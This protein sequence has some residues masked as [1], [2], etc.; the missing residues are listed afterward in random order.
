MSEYPPIA[1]YGLIGDCHSVALV[2]RNGSV[3]WCCM[4]RIDSSPCFARLLDWE[5]GGCCSI[6]PVPEEARPTFRSYIEG[7]LVLET[8][9]RTARGQARVIDCFD[10]DPADTER[11]DRRERRLIRIIEGQRGAFEFD[12]RI[13]PRF[14]YGEVDPWIRHHGG[15]LYSAMGGDA[16]LVIWCDAELEPSGRHDLAGRARVRP[17]ERVRLAVTSGDPVGIDEPGEVGEMDSAELDDAVERTIAWWREWSERSAMEGPD[18]PGAERSAVVLKALTYEPTGAIAA[19]ATTSLP[20]SVEGERNWDYRQSWI[21]D[22]AMAVRSLAELGFENEAS[23]FRAFIERSAAGNAKDLQVLYGLGGERRLPEHTLDHLEGYRGVGPVRIGN[24]AIAQ[25]QLDAYGHLLEQ[26][27]GWYQKGHEPDDDYWRFILELV[28]TAAER[29][30][31]PDAGIWEW[32]EPQQFVHSKALAWVA[33][34]RGLLLAERCMRKAPERR[35]R[36]VRD[37]LREAIESKGYDEGRGVFLQRFGES[38]LDAAL[39]RLPALGFLDYDDERMVRTVDAIREDL[40]CD[41]LIRRYSSDDGIGPPE[42]AFIPAT[43]WLAECLAGQRRLGEARASFDRALSTANG[44]GLFSEEYDPDRKEM[45]GNFPQTLSHLS[46]L[47]AA[48]ALSKAQS[49]ATAGQPAGGA[50]T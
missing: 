27:W 25:F 42:G 30:A 1:D 20:E 34:D 35:W 7:T 23:A 5:R 49:A 19:A 36:S 37:E 14:D 4:P 12:L 3:D 11:D 44:L 43:F 40:D 31:E 32:R 18:S 21:R 28:D 6:E 29:W 22:S 33:L 13:S 2:S 26:S 45:L 8:S 39:L 47:E 24:A 46:H 17:G 9:M 16:G 48:L 41:G 38:D 10:I 50:A 15:D